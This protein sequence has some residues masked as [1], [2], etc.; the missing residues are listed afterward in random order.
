MVC[1]QILMQWLKTPLGEDLQ[2]NIRFSIQRLIQQKHGPYLL[3]L[4]LPD[5]DGLLEQTAIPFKWSL[6]QSLTD[7]VYYD[8]QVNF[9]TLPFENEFFNMI[10]FAYTGLFSHNVQ[11]I[12]MEIE[13]V[14]KSDGIA[15]IFDL[16][17][18]SLLRLSMHRFVR[19]MAGHYHFQS[20]NQMCQAI[21][22]SDLKIVSIEPHFFQPPCQNKQILAHTQF[23]EV[24][25]PLSLLIP[26]GAYGIFVKKVS[27]GITAIPKQA[28]TLWRLVAPLRP[29]V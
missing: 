8:V 6:S 19:A 15:F 22:R 3:N 14:L 23:L 24:W 7:P 26:A 12:L 5:L 13:R 20:L 17:P 27:F 18:I 25:G 1:E 2:R 4:G 29:S 28:P 16:H 9:E 10:I 11:P 21:K